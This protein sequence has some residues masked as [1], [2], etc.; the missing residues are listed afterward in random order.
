MKN[1]LRVTVLLALSII[2]ALP[3]WGQNAPDSI[4]ICLPGDPDSAMEEQ[5]ASISRLM[6]MEEIAIAVDTITA[7]YDSDWK[8]LSMQGKLSFTGL[9]MRVSVKV[10][11]ERGKSIILSARAPFL[12]EVARVEICA[13]SIVFI[14]KHSRTYNTQP[15]AGLASDP[16]A[17]LCDIQDIL[18]GQV[19]LPGHGRMTPAL[20][21]GAQWIAITDSDA[22][23][24]PFKDYQID[25]TDYGFVMDASCWQLSAFVL[26]LQKAG[27][28]VQTTYQYREDDWTLGLEIDLQ[29]KR[30]KG[31]V[32]LT[33][34][35]YA[36]TPLEFTAIGNKY[37]RVEM[38]DIMKF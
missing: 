32:E 2:V 14:N 6:T 7:N 20:S 15:L 31:D 38:K 35:D 27:V 3:V 16:Q 5:P 10:Y 9:P 25:G 23:I 21:S 26:M 8:D 17:Y 36:P 13:D 24:Y 19:A 18:L 33:Y 29:K 11:M 1:I 12:G 34:P 28:V 30:L 37:R 22:L 4:A